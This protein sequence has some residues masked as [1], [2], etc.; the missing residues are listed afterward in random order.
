LALAIEAGAPAVPKDGV[1]AVYGPR[2]GEDLS[3]LPKARTVIITGFK[4]DHDH[5]EAQGFQC[6]PGADGPF[7]LSVVFAPRAKA[8]AHAMIAD[9][10][11][12]TDGIVIVDGA[13]TDGIEAL[14][15]ACRKRAD[16]SPALSKSHGKLFHFAANAGFT[17]WVFQEPRAIDGGFVTRP[18]IFSADGV[19]P[20]SRLLANHLPRSLGS[21]VAD[22]GAGWGYLS[23]RILERDSIETLD[24]VEAEFAALRCAEA[25]IDD[26]RA[27]FH[28][29]DVSRWQGAVP[30]DSIVSNPPFHV[31]RKAE[32]VIGQSFIVAASRLL[33]PRGQL[34][35][36]ANRHLPYES[37]LEESF[38]EVAEFGGDTRFKLLR[39]ARPKRRARAR[40]V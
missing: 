4:P 35:L 19:D 39:A 8:L 23:A 27:R 20:A 29:A 40:D 26:S 38:S 9:A 24:L 10:A 37:V 14:F 5:F 11:E 12:R 2:V 17:D 7:A 15:K 31:S 1:V 32:P 33:A 6:V 21:H 13:K 34:F 25:N 3:F 28:W 36:V 22:L 18:G 16:V 30:L